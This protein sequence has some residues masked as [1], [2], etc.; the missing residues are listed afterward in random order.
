MSFVP[1]HFTSVCL[2]VPESFTTCRVCE[3]EEELSQESSRSADTILTIV[4]ECKLVDLLTPSNTDMPTAE[5]PGYLVDLAVTH[6]GG[7]V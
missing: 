5:N 6:V 7:Q 1:R 4:C 3:E 2:L